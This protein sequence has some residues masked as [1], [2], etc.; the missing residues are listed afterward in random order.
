MAVF[1]R[2]MNHLDP[3]NPQQA[4]HQLTEYISYMQ[5]AMEF[6]M[7]KSAKE[8]ATKLE[9]IEKRLDALEKKPQ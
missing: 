7:A 3:K 6:A 8:N 2:T 5:E 9:A 1:N 4:F